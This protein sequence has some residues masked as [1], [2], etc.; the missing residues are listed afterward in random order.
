MKTLTHWSR[1]PI[2]NPLLLGFG[3]PE[4]IWVGSGVSQVKN[5]FVTTPATVYGTHDDRALRLDRRC[6]QSSAAKKS[7]SSER[8]GRLLIKARLLIEADQ[9]LLGVHPSMRTSSIPMSPTVASNASSP[10]GKPCSGDFYQGL[11]HRPFRIG[12]CHCLMSSF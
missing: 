3:C 8:I 4:G 2:R 7:E 1:V 9:A 10:F 6:L 12:R 11:H 5:P